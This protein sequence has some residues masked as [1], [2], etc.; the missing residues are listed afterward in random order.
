MFIFE[1][2]SKNDKVQQMNSYTYVYNTI[3]ET[4]SANGVLSCLHC[5]NIALENCNDPKNSTIPSTVCE[6]DGDLCYSQHTPFGVIDR[7]CFSVNH[8]LSTYV[9]SCNLCNYIPITE[10]PYIFLSKLDWIDNVVDLSYARRLRKSVLKEMSCLRC[11]TNSSIVNGMNSM[12]ETNCLEGNM[13]YCGENEVC[14]VKAVK[15]DGYMWRGCVKQ[16]L[17]NYWWAL[18]DTDLCNYDAVASVYDVL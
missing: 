16:P 18:C 14:A 15:K 8:N 4:K 9:C 2:D 7:G 17:Y 6:R 5:N 12:D 1:T 10:M 11:E 3:N 13:F